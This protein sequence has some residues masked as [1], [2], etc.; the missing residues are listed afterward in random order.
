[1]SGTSSPAPRKCGNVDYLALD[2]QP[3]S[4]SPHRKV[5]GW[6]CRINLLQ[7]LFSVTAYI[8]HN[9]VRPQARISLLPYLSFHSPLHPL[10][11]LTRRW[12]MCKLTRRRPRHCKAPC[13]S[14]LMCGSLLKLLRGSSPDNDLL[15]RLKKKNGIQIL[16][17]A[18]LV[19]CFY[20]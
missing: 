18:S 14:G 12:T 3:G 5:N 13:R 10:W 16:S 4:P 15:K 19:L 1:M 9:A 2:F 8:S 20:H 7:H 17:Q 11:P 6:F